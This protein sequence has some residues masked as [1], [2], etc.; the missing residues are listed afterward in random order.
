MRESTIDWTGRVAVITGAAG[1]IGR[2]LAERCAAEG[3]RLVLA[4]VEEGALR[5]LV[6]ELARRRVEL[7]AQVVDVAQPEQVERLA[8]RTLTHFG[9]VDILFNNAGVNATPPGRG[10]AWQASP[11]DWRWVLGV[12]L[13]G[14]ANGLRAFVPAMLAQGGPAYIV[15][16]ASLSG[17]VTHP[18]SAVYQASKHAVVA[19]SE[20]LHHELRE[21]GSAIRVAVICPAAV[22]TDIATADR[23]RPPELADPALP[24][25]DPDDGVADDAI[26]RRYWRTHWTDIIE[27]EEV[28]A[29]VFEALPRGTF[30]ILTQPAHNPAIAHRFQAMT[31]GG[32]PAE[33]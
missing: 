27:P 4:D 20:A 19:L 14:V 9:A 26:S 28:A 21:M 30:Y 13:E 5:P 31:A 23:N 25:D 7:L 2:A 10:Y 16:S 15:N 32:D 3:M 11:A 18:G 24:D 22:R 6:N 33:P 29:A 1:G 8:Q 17:L 12:N